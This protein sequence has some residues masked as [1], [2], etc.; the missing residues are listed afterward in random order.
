MQNTETNLS[1][2]IFFSVIIP[3]YN[4]EKYITR[5]ID[6]ILKQEFESWELILVNDASTD[7]TK[8][9]IDSI[10]HP[11][12]K[13]IH[14]E[15]NKE[16]CAS[17]NIGIAASMGKYICFLD[18]DD[19]HLPN[20]LSELYKIIQSK[21][22]PEAIFFTNAFDESA[23]GVRSDRCCPVFE[24]Y[25]PYSYFLHYTVNPQRW[26]VHRNIFN[27]ISFDTDI[28]IGEDM[29]TSM[30][31]IAAGYNAFQ[32]PVRTTVYVAAPDSFTHSDNNKWNKQIFYF[33]KIF[34]KEIF[35]WKLPL[36]DR[37]RLLSMCYFHLALQA[38]TEKNRLLFYNYAIKS[39]VMCPKGYN[40]KTNKIL[41]VNMVYSLPLLGAIIKTVIK[42][43]KRNRE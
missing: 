2:D 19:Y 22:F 9:I 26:A 37:W 21:K 18:S 14:N 3:V 41:F 38:V 27:H 6:S 36:K 8:K 24:Q 32:H 5:A 15:A 40:G 39:F 17:R 13:A 11:K 29:D 20:H 23:D 34:A 31:I 7:G 43:I 33:K 30:R 10:H 42:K 4:R 35:K 25:N 28:V 16:R 1:N 12:I